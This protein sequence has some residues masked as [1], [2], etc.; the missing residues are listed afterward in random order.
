M[1]TEYAHWS[2]V[3]VGDLYAWPWRFFSPKEMACRG[4]G[5]LVI[6]PEFMQRLTGARTVY[7]KK[8]R[9]S[10][11][12]STPEHNASVS[13]SGLTGPH[14]TARAIDIFVFGG[15]YI[16]LKRIAMA[17]GFTGFGS[18]QKGPHKRRFL[19]LDDLPNAP[20]QPRPWGWTY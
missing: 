20:G 10:R 2:Q 8:V 12:Y 11:G 18:N 17:H 5:K 19:H 14:T 6:V 7:G 15:D 1:Q 16:L 13:K 3:D 9:V 4:T